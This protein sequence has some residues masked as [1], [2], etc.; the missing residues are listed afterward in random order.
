MIFN[1]TID[2]ILSLRGLDIYFKMWKRKRKNTDRVIS[3]HNTILDNLPKTA[4]T[5]NLI[6]FPNTQKKLKSSS[7]Y[8][9]NDN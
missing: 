3:E 1:K 5:S 7:K 6:N 4:F 9:Y 8:N 2:W